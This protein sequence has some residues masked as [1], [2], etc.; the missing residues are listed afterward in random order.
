[1]KLAEQ[2]RGALGAGLE[3]GVELGG[4]E[5][6]VVVELDHLDEALVGRGARDAQAGALRGA[7]AAGC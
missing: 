2:R 6:R 4:D 5:E 7:C 1:M 3:L